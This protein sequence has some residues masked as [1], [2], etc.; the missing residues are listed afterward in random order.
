MRMVK[1]HN[2]KINNRIDRIRQDILKPRKAKILIKREQKAFATLLEVLIAMVLAAIVLSTLTFFYRQVNLIGR[3]L[4]ETQKTSF[5]MR[6]L[7]NRLSHILPKI[8]PKK[9]KVINQNKETV[10]INEDFAFF[11]ANDSYGLTQQGSQSVIFTYNNNC[12]LDKVF[13]NHVIGRLYVD[14]NDRL[15]LAYWPSPIHWESQHTLPMKREVLL[16]NVKELAF[17]FFIAPDKGLEQNASE[18]QNN[19]AEEKK[20]TPEPKGG[21]RK[22]NE[23]WPQQF[24]ELPAIVKVIVTRNDDSK[25]LMFLFPLLNNLKPIIYD[26]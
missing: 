19:M 16:E 8:I 13:S 2:K 15:M 11:T 5:Q 22:G 10:K 18:E 9:E 17:E 20:S 26:Y 21:W 23:G 7:E 3:E 1:S 4:D 14:S 24:D 25:P 6:F 12:C